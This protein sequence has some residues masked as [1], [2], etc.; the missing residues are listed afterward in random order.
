MAELP[1]PR[2]FA[3]ASKQVREE[4]VAKQVPC[5]DDVDAHVRAPRRFVDAGFTHVAVVQ[6]GGDTQPT[7]LDWAE[8]ELLRALRKLRFDRWGIDSALDDVAERGD[9]MGPAL[10]DP[11]SPATRVGTRRGSGWRGSPT[12][13]DR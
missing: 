7:F 3:A 6:I 2:S 13:D 12:S 9:L 11:Q 5:G 1:G 10:N 4:D 8:R